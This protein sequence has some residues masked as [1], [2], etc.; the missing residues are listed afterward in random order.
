MKRGDK[1]QQ[2]RDRRWEMGDRR[3]DIGGGRQE[4][5][6]EIKKESPNLLKC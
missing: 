6:K 2:N 5:W 4:M 3:Q 1:R